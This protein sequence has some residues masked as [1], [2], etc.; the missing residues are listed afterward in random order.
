[1]QISIAVFSAIHDILNTSQ[2]KKTYFVRLLK[3]ILHVLDLKNLHNET[4]LRN[5]LYGILYKFCEI[6]RHVLVFEKFTQRNNFAK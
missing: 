2:G 6:S 4:I 3:L 1:M 5:N